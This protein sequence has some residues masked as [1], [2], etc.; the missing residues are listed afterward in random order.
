MTK[1]LD[2]LKRLAKRHSIKTP[3][4]FHP[5]YPSESPYRYHLVTNDGQL[6]LGKNAQAARF[7]LNHMGENTK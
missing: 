6:A 3:V 2:R 1:S 4:V 7:A 5:E